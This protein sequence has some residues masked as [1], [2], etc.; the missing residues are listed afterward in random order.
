MTTFTAIVS[1]ELVSLEWADSELQKLIINS[2]VI[3]N[4][5]ILKYSL[6]CSWQDLLI[7]TIS[8]QI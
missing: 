7:N 3:Y 8:K 4:K 2:R 5:N 1:C 6:I